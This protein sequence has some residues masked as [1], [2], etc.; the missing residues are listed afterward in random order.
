MKP[1]FLFLLFPLALQAQKVS[2]AALTHDGHE[3][4]VSFTLRP[5]AMRVGANR[6]LTLTPLITNEGDTLRLAP[7]TVIGRRRQIY[8]DRNGLQ[9]TGTAVISAR[10][11]N[12]LS[13]EA[14]TE[15]QPWMDCASLQLEARETGCHQCETDHSLL[16]L[17]KLCPEPKPVVAPTPEPEPVVETKREWKP[18]LAY[19]CPTSKTSKIQTL[20][21][22]AYIDFPV[23]RTEIN[24]TYRRNAA[25][26][27]RIHET[28]M[29]VVRDTDVTFRTL[30]VKGYASPEG[31]YANN[32]RLAQ[33]RTE[34]LKRYVATRYAIDPSLI[35]TDYEPEDW[36]GL[37]DTLQ[38]LPLLPH[39]DDIL[40]LARQ[41][42]D[43]DRREQRIRQ[44]YPAAYQYIHENIYPALRHS[45][46]AVTYEVRQFVTN[47]DLL[48]V[49]R[50][51]PGR[52]SLAELFQLANTMQRGSREFN[53]VFALAVRLYPD[54]P[55][56]NLNA[57]NAALERQDATAAERY[58]RKAG[59]SP[60]A[61][62][63]RRVLDELRA[64]LTRP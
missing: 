10:A 14:T 11:E 2:D 32:A 6:E 57:A 9:P 34:A 37:I 13:Y 58:L 1:L 15:W 30:T 62:Q 12:P 3:A 16:L 45:D 33:G 41:Q 24:D 60:E 56:A 51:N 21:G 8:M 47:D 18:Q 23:N 44:L 38:S 52:L 31:T 26:L 53:E 43:P 7:V 54:D 20:E 42:G 40:A 29:A 17:A 19:L 5:A 28:V 64:Y 55:T 36:Q 4:R 46:Y 27:Q 35:L 49:Y 63:A 48:R 25:E 59:Y 39:R 22:R 50:S 61:Q